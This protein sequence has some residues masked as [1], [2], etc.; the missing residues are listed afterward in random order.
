MTV[1]LV[2]VFI[3]FI[4][5]G[6]PDSILGA[7]WP[8]MYRDLDL[9]ISLAGYITATVSGCTIISSLLS[10]KFINK[11]GTGTVATVSTLLTALALLG[12][13][14]TSSPIFLFVLAAPLGFGAGAVDAAL[15]GFVALHYSASKMSYLHCFYG[16][17][18]SAS[19]LVMSLVLDGGN[20][21]SGYRIMSAVQFV[22]ALI[23]FIALPLWR[24]AKRK[25]VAENE[26][27]SKT[28]SLKQLLKMPK[29]WLSGFTF[30]LSDAILICAGSWSSSYFVD[31]RGLN[32][33][34]AARVTMLYYIGLA[35][36]RF[37]SGVF[38][39]RI[40]QRK[41]IKTSIFVLPIAL[42]LFALPLNI[43]VGAGA[44]FIIGMGIGPV[45]PNL[46]HLTPEIFGRDIAQSVMGVQQAMC[47]AGIMLMP[48]LFGLLAQ[49]F[50]TA[51]LPYYVIT[52]FI[53]Y[54]SIFL[55]LMKKGTEN[56]KGKN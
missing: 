38:A 34:K 48:S 29:V 11:F 35:A 5:L 33:D 54:A 4:G 30:F 17:G 52:M 28:L 50:S 15:N 6:T 9:P 3:M 27:P 24:K 1:L 12:Y 7:A 18:I 16:L 25:D 14:F 55:V 2:V 40:G 20:W 44:L 10:S 47:Y 19:P 13:S 45:Y 49:L 41:L 22:I 43:T 37:L 53:I 39:D 21:R 36:G 42:I 46:A 56:G 23:G 8:V 32:P 51:I 26:A 31:F